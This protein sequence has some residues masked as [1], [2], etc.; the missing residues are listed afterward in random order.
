MHLNHPINLFFG[1]FIWALWFVFIYTVLSI[2]CVYQGHGTR[3]NWINIII[4]SS[5]MLVAF[6][7]LRL[8]YACYQALKQPRIARGKATMLMIVG[9]LNLAGALATI[10]IGATAF[11]LPPCI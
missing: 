11:Y 10:T 6:F 8:A 1:F 2:G 3:L 7:L 5:M 4:I 9:L